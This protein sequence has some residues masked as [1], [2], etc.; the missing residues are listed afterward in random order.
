TAPVVRAGGS[1]GDAAENVVHSNSGG[2]NEGQAGA[3]AAGAGGFEEE[4]EEVGEE[5]NNWAVIVSTSRYW[6]NYR[7]TA[8]ALTI[9]FTVKRLGVPDSRIILMLADD[10][11]CTARN[12]FPGQIFNS[13][14]RSFNLYGVTAPKATAVRQRRLALEEAARAAAAAARKARRRPGAIDSEAV[15]ERHLR[16]VSSFFN[17]SSS[18]ASPD[19][20]RSSP[21]SSSPASRLTLLSESLG[22]DVEVDYRGEEVHVQALLR[23]LTGRHAAETPRGQRLLSDSRSHVMVYLTGHGGEN[24][25]K[26]QDWEEIG[27]V[28]LADAVAQMHRQQ[29]YKR[30]LLIAETCQGSTLLDSIYSPNVLG[31]ASSK[32]EESSYSHHADSALGVSVVDRWTYFTWQFFRQHVFRRRKRRGSRRNS[33]TARSDTGRKEWDRD[34]S[35]D[36]DGG[37]EIGDEADDRDE[38]DEEDEASEFSREE[39]AEEV[40]SNYFRHDRER[41]DRHWRTDE[42]Q[43]QKR[44]KKRRGQKPRRSKTVA[45]LFRSY[46][47]EKLMS[48][49]TTRTDL[50][51]KPLEDTGLDEF[52]SA[53]TGV[54]TPT[55]TPYWLPSPEEAKE[56]QQQHR[57]RQRK[58]QRQLEEDLWRQ[59][60]RSHNSYPVFDVLPYY[61]ESFLCLL[62]DAGRASDARG[63]PQGQQQEEEQQGEEEQ[64]QEEES[65][66]RVESSGARIGD[67]T[68]CPGVSQNSFS[69][70]YRKPSGDFTVETFYTSEGRH[71]YSMSYTHIRYFVDC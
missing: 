36:E 15:F 5:R 6:Q 41:T 45:D 33:R 12:P 46:S 18:S 56:Q 55:L 1:G 21:S 29:R 7:H 11:A 9:Y 19:P 43:R 54:V 28:D 61:R 53:A 26:F 65:E 13:P 68:C 58:S 16:R 14:R 63:V 44:N 4:E 2:E 40:D 59:Q 23:L 42:T 69:Q 38:G 20:H 50:F 24:F 51:D 27:A 39:E 22:E 34:F 64:K 71:N 25:L 31:M 67:G 70:L 66:G 30:L 52:F 60:R 10:H 49:A 17:S 48:T 8:N 3:E 57:R 62:C 32:L 35:E 37:E 47:F